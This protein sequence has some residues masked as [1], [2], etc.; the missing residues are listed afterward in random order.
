MTRYKLK[1][2]I[3][4]RIKILL[5]LKV[6]LLSY[7]KSESSFNSRLCFVEHQVGTPRSQN[8]RSHIKNND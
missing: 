2:P 8:D 7:D 5:L 6:I 1:K 3:K 4:V